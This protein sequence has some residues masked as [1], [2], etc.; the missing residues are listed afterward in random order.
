MRLKVQRYRSVKSN[1]VLKL[2]PHPPFLWKRDTLNLFSH[3]HSNS[4]NP[5][6]QP[7]SETI[8]AY[9]DFNRHPSKPINGT[10]LTHRLY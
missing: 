4:Q 3:S 6:Q 9:E 8:W 1:F 2:P 7:D 10:I 5:N